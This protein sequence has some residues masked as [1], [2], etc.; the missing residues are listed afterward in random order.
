[1]TKEEHTT[2]LNNLRECEQESEQANIIL[3]LSTDYTDILS[4]LL[5]AQEQCKAMTAENKSLC[6]LN[7]KMFLQLANTDNSISSCAM[8]GNTSHDMEEP[9]KREFKNL[10]WE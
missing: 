3:S 2:L 7:K 5:K 1:M 9:K 6:E 8:D 4:Q 10:K